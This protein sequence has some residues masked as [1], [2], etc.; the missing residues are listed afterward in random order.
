[1]ND[2]AKIAKMALLLAWAAVSFPEGIIMGAR[3]SA[4][5]QEVAEFVDVEAVFSGG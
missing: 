4:P 3:G 2:V 5:V 1:M